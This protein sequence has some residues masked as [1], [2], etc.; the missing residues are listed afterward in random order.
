MQS[1]VR[2][3]TDKLI[4][5]VGI[6]NGSLSSYKVVAKMV[7]IQSFDYLPKVSLEHQIIRIFDYGGPGTSTSRLS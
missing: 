1:K 3:G 5:L 4:E 6:M 2:V 7:G